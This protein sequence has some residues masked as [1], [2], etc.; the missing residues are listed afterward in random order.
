MY[1]PQC[2]AEERVVIAD[3]DSDTMGSLSIRLG[4][5]GTRKKDPGRTIKEPGEDRW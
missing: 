5:G 2:A 3:S 1:E 4:L